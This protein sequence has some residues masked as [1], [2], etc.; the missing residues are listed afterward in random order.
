MDYTVIYTKRK[1]VGISIKEGK[2][3]V[4]SPKR[5][6]KK[7]LDEIVEKHRE[8]IEKTILREEA[9]RENFPALSTQQIKELRENAKE[10]FGKICFEYAKIMGV[11]YSS[12]KITSAKKRFGS[13]SSRKSLCFSFYTMLYPEKAR[14]Y[15]VIHELAH[16]IHMNHSKKFYSLVEKFMPDYKEREKIIRQGIKRQ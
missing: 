1:T 9:K 16:L 4:R 14:E 13:C 12:I 8:W 11:E 6:S 10:Y 2:V 5:I 7:K 3:Y 15:V